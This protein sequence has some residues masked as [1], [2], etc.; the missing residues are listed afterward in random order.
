[1]RVAIIMLFAVGC[2][3]L[4]FETSS[5]DAR[6]SLDDWPVR[7][8]FGL[9]NATRDEALVDFPVMV[10]LDPTRF[11]YTKAAADGQD[12]RFTDVAGAALAYE[13]EAWQPGGRSIVWVSVPR[14][15]ANSD[16]GAIIMYSGNP[17]APPP[18]IA[19]RMTWSSNYL[20]VFHMAGRLADSTATELA[21]STST[22]VYSAGPIAEA[23]TL[24]HDFAR[25]QPG[26]TVEAIATMSGLMRVDVEDM[27][28]FTSLITAPIVGDFPDRLYLGWH[29]GGPFAEITN[30]S[31]MTIQLEAGASML[32]RWTHLGLV[33]DNGTVTLYVDGKSV[34]GSAYQGMLRPRELG[35]FIGADCDQCP[36]DVQDASSDYLEGA[37]DELRFEGVA[38][39]AAW[40]D[41]QAAA[42]R[43]E[44]V[45]Y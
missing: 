13:I 19:A 29:T 15:E 5:P 33:L 17:S 4:A 6:G 23:M 18:S 2:G 42:L 34:T 44:L 35:L 41:A 25:I 1:M 16:A 24:T 3:R 11:D 32:H 21:G 9:R 30:D 39:S 12:L 8:R 43:D 37:V 14:I 27:S 10:A 38:R 20:A 45:A 26:S 28:G 7:Q 40:M 31:G 36:L 22:V